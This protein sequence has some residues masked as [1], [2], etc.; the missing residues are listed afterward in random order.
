M[1]RLKLTFTLIFL[2]VLIQICIFL[3]CANN[4]TDNPSSPQVFSDPKKQNSIILR[5]GT[6]SYTNS[7]FKKYIF[8]VAGGDIE[9]LSY[10]TLSRLLDSFIEEKILL[11]DARLKNVTLTSDEKKQYLAALSRLHRGNE[12]NGPADNFESKIL[13]EKLLVEKHT[14]ELVKDISVNRGSLTEDYAQNKREFLRPETVLASQILLATETKAIEIRERIKNASEEEFR[15]SAR[16]ESSG[17]EASQG[18]EMGRFELGQLPLDM[19]QVI[20]ALQVGEISRVFE[21]S[22]GY[23]IFRL[24]DKFGPELISEENASSEIEAKIL[25]KRIKEYMFNY[26][27]KYKSQVEWNF[28]PENL[29]FPYQ[30]K[31]HE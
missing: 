22:Y 13:F 16:A 5:I 15:K 18:G 28:Y 10:V 23:H 26:L 21:S 11:E 12:T 4:K 7:D 2:F 3:S 27:E 29:P 24:D 1:N 19:E 14:V 17:T 31:N 30:R 6:S 9:E 8:L 20:F 25:D